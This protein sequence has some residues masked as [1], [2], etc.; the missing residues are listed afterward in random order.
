M[1]NINAYQL[2]NCE[3]DNIGF[4]DNSIINS[5]KD[6]EVYFRNIEENLFKYIKEADIVLGCVAWLTSETILTALAEKRAVSIIVQKEDFLRPD[7]NSSSN[8]DKWK[9]KLKYYYNNLKS[10][11][12]RY[13]FGNILN[14]ISYCTDPTIEP[15]RCVGN[16][17]KDKKP[18]FPRMHNKF[19][20]FAKRLDNNEQE[21]PEVI[22]YGVWT[23]SYNLSKNAQRSLENAIF[24][25]DNDIV[26]AYYKEFGQIAA[27]SEPLD[28]ESEWIAPEWRIGS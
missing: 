2:E 5:D 13:E 27:M 20:V 14:S 16:Y 6:I 9:K 7:M 3:N 4:E 24:I 12:C 11:L 21:L 15:I 17:N 8:K 10:D 23:G 18:A 22:P 19:L 1:E 26:N 25:R 28:W